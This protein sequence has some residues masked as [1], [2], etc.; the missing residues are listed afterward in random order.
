RCGGV[1]RVRPHRGV[2][3]GRR[4]PAFPRKR[5][6]GARGKHG[7]L[8][9]REPPE[10]CSEGSRLVGA[11]GFEP[12]TTGPPV[13]CATGLR[14]APMSTE[15]LVYTTPPRGWWAGRESNPEHRDYKS[16]V[17]AALN[18]RPVEMGSGGRRRAYQ[19][20]GASRCRS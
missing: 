3:R 13:R 12:A 11:T 2:A 1:G 16:R 8:K 17:L 5:G 18:Y 9:R 4:A 10:T 6:G 15:T 19:H 7:G 20:Q 14:Y